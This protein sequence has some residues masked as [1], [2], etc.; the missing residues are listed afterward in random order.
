MENI[1]VTYRDI[2]IS[3]NEDCERWSCKIDDGKW[4]EK[5]TLKEC[6]KLIDLFYKKQVENIECIYVSASSY[7]CGFGSKR[8]I[9]S[10]SEN[11]DVWV[12]NEKG[13]REKYSQY[14]LKNDLALWN[15]NNLKIVD[16]YK[17]QMKVVKQESDKANSI[18]SKLERFAQHSI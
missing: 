3:Y 8:I 16:E 15:E 18:L 12:K 4:S 17:E 6:K 14:S 10:I 1:K 11:G 5:Q 9:T 7:K 2:E 13:N